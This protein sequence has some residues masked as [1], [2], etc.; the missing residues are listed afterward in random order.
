M[1][2]QD[3]NST[4]IDRWCEEGWQW[5]QPIS[6]E[7][8]QRATEKNFVVYLTPTRPV[9][10]TWFPDLKGLKVL[11]LASGGGQQMPIFAKLGAEGTVI[12]YSER[13]LASERLVAEREGYQIEVIRAD[14]SEPLPLPDASFDLVFHPVSNVY[15]EDVRSIFKECYRVLKPGGIL[16]A[17]LDNGINFLTSDEV[18][19][20]NSLPFNPLKNPEQMEKLLKDDDGVQFSH[21]LEEQIGGQLEAGFILTD[22]FE[23]FNGQGRLSELNIPTFFAT[24]A[25]KKC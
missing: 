4:A 8:Y 17:G 5:G 7:E 25:I 21:T 10:R 22:L 2:Y 14:M 20:E 11:G 9:P 18:H 15:V 24:R 12:D 1:K 16:L 3:I 19:I 6:H 23:D 13:Q